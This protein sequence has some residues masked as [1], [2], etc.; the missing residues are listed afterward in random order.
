M[1]PLAVAVAAAPAP[2]PARPKTPPPSLPSAGAGAAAALSP[3]AAEALSHVDIEL[4]NDDEWRPSEVCD[5]RAAVAAGNRAEVERIMGLY[6]ALDGIPQELSD[7]EVPPPSRGPSVKAEGPRKAAVPVPTA[8]ATA[9]VHPSCGGAGPS[10]AGGGGS[11]A[12]CL[13]VLAPGRSDS[14]YARQLQAE[15]E[16]MA[17]EAAA[18][19]EA[20]QDE[21]MAAAMAASLGEGGGLGGGGSSDEDEEEEEPV[22]GVRVS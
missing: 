11:L 20:L 8:V 21:E 13:P 18:R 17:L 22:M 4:R 16:A 12:G 14:D 6:G 7:G 15:E 19:F 5:L 10:S 9:A 3:P 1:P 2:P